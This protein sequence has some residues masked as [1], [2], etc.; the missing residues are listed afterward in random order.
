MAGSLPPRSAIEKKFTWNAESVF[1]HPAAWKA[2]LSAVLADLPGLA[3]A[4]EAMRRDAAG[5]ADGLA[6]TEKVQ[7]RMMRVMV[8]A[9]YSYSVNTLDG[10][11]A[12]MNDEAQG[13]WGQVSSAVAFVDPLLLELGRETL[14]AWTRSEPRLVPYGH[15]FDNLFRRQS[16]VRSAEVEE[17]MGMLA[18]PFFGPENTASMLLNADLRFADAKDAK[19]RRREVSQGRL[20]RIMEETDRSARRSA[21]ESY[22][23]GHL[24]VRNTVAATLTTSIKQNVFRSRARRFSSSLEAALEPDNIPVPVFHNAIDTFRRNLPLWHRYFDLRRKVLK[25]KS[26]GHYDMWAPLTKKRVRIPFEEAVEMICEGLSPMGEEYVAHVRRGCLKERWVDVYP[27]K[28]KREGA[29]SGGSPGTHPFIMMSW[30]DDIT[31]LSTLAHEL[32]HSL[33]SLY[34]WRTQPFTYSGYSTFV[35]EVASN[36]HQAL[37]RASLLERKPAL[38]VPVIEEA[39]ANYFRYFFIMPTLARFEL[40]THRRVEKG[41]PLSADVMMDAMTELLREAYGPTVN[42]DREREGMLWASFPHLYMDYYVFQYE[43]GIAG[44]QALASRVLRGEHGAAPA[45]IRFISAGGS[46]YP[47]DILKQA[48]VDLSKPQPVQEAFEVMGG[49]VARLEELLL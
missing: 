4:R 1:A 33:H 11:A 35:A 29:F 42:V 43:T 24:S 37:V 40:E 34:T 38:Q 2:E 19:G 6:A 18:D 32:G 47:V 26:L 17:L 41:E 22:M 25:L 31:S 8:Y 30:V 13:A 28:G 7:E 45:Y 20:F 14:A 36:F 9:Y 27:N 5:L 10:K 46:G 16:H 21:W 44:A 48:G 12:A 23:A 3:A 15:A 39:M 49:Y